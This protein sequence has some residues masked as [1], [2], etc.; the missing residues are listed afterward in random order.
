[1]YCLNCVADLVEDFPRLW[2][3]YSLVWE[4]LHV[5]VQIP[6]STVLQY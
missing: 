4:L 5:M 3:T 6:I 2:L 1:M